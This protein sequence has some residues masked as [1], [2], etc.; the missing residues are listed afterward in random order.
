MTER[1]ISA[2]PAQLTEQRR[3]P[4]RVLP[5]NGIVT[6]VKSNMVEGQFGTI[7]KEPINK[8]D[9]IFTITG[10]I[11]DHPTVYTFQYGPTEHLDPKNPD[12][13][14]SF[15]HFTN[16]SCDPTAYI[17]IV[18]REEGETTGRIE[19]VARKDMPKGDEVSVDYAA[20]E[21]DPV[22]EG[23]QCQCGSPMCRGTI[24]GFKQLDPDTKAI[25]IEEGIISKYLI[26]LDKAA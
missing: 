4:E 13:T 17:R 5:D 21:Y 8:G 1:G 16:H 14:P 6:V 11:L 20:M 25:Y 12:G 15:G 18:E 7:A 22:A 10:P 23:L 24:E 9:V 19:V 3:T 26:E 2:K